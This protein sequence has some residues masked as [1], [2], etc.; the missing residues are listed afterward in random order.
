[1]LDDLGL[2]PTLRWYIENYGRRLKI[3]THYEAIGFTEKLNPELEIVLYRVIQE[4]LN[5]VAKHAHADDV[6]VHLNSAD[7]SIT[8]TITDNGIGF[9]PQNVFSMNIGKR[10]FGIMG[11]QERVS[12]LGGRV[13]IRSRPGRGTQIAIEIPLEIS[14]A[15][16]EP[17]EDYSPYC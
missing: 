7:S 2:L 15:E 4:A 8:V 3:K 5:N 17:Q 12:S 9:D 14:E 16:D 11:M 1:M 10:G 13:D 6:H